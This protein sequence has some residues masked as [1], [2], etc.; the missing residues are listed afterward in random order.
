M[1]DLVSHVILVQVIEESFRNFGRLARNEP[2]HAFVLRVETHRIHPQHPELVQQI[3][4][5]FRFAVLRRRLANYLPEDPIEMGQG[6]K[7]DIVGNL[8]DSQMRIE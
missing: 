6:L 7:A 3:P 4:D 8:T 2:T 5:R 1:Q